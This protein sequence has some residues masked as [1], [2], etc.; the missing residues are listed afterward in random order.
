MFSFIFFLFEASA[1][2]AGTSFFVVRCVIYG[3]KLV[4]VVF[5][6]CV[7]LRPARTPQAFFLLS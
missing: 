2:A 7:F 5:S 3:I 4:V 6:T 1:Y